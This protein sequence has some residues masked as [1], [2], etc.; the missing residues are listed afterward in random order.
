MGRTWKGA[1]LRYCPSIFLEGLSEILGMDNKCPSQ[2]SNMALQGSTANHHPVM[3][4]KC[5]TV[6]K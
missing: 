6:T 4:L 2:D 1:V 5:H 3:F